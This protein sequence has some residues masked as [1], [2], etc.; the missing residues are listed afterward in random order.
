MTSDLAHLRHADTTQ[1][2]EVADRIWW[3]GHVL[4]N[5]PFQCHVYLLEQGD[6][7]V[8]F[9]PGSR[10][11]FAGTLGKIEQVIPFT[12]IRYF[13]CHHQ[14]PDITAAL[15][16]IDDMTNRPDACIVT[17]W[18]AQA[19]LRHYGLKLP[20]WLVDQHE[21]RLQLQD[22][23][24]EFIFTPYAHFPG[25]ICSFDRR[26]RVLFSSDLFG[27]FTQTPTLVAQD[28]SHFEALRPFHEHYMPSNDILGYALTQIERYPVEIIC[29]QHGSIIPRPLIGF[30]IEK[31]RHINC[32]IY[33]L[34]QDDTDI[35]RLSRLN[36]TLRD[37]AETML[38][39]R[40]F[41]DIATRLLELVQRSLPVERLDY[42]A[43]LSDSNVLVL[44]RE[45]RFSGTIESSIH[46]P[47]FCTFIGRNR[48]DWIIIHNDTLATHGHCLH[49][50]LFCVDK[51]ADSNEQQIRIPLVGHGQERID[52]FAVM[53]LK[54]CIPITQAVIQIV[55]QIAEPLQVAL[56]R[57][58]IY[59][60]I[61]MERE[62]AYQRSIR[63]S[64]TGLFTRFYMHDVMTRYC[65][66]HDR[67]RDAEVTA[68]LIDIDHFKRVNDTY[69]H[70]AGDRV[71]QQVGVILSRESRST[72]V[73]VRYGG[74]EFIIFVV[75]KSDSCL[76]A[77]RLR[78]RIAE[79][80]F[81]I[82]TN[83]PLHVT[84]SFGM[85]QRIQTEVLENL[86]RRADEA[87]YCAKE[88]GRNRVVNASNPV[89]ENQ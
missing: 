33:L 35:Q 41:R 53:T 83:A 29:S 26:T 39:Y 70:G 19:L 7:S 48:E 54:T 9:D 59:R 58:V 10:L 74:E 21:W 12:H 71:L 57:E 30:M 45:T 68:I 28:E 20:F 88:T 72:D 3:V 34:V 37:I 25:A 77:E 61:D 27:G 69:G 89:L 6:Q 50:E 80:A 67:D 42:Y 64:L 11:T 14:D 40:D 17:H 78:L 18:R 79:H 4:P 82:D 2:L 51:D 32:G 75:G 15:P 85:A 23:E 44:K 76:F 52:G 31:L 13:V 62:R 22:R 24:L 86:I 1:A 56:E 63:D 36:A 46:L 47:Y 16:L 73:V 43:A 38:L 8:L 87:L 60:M 84:A 66:L 5:D 49:N 65:N 55:S 81:D